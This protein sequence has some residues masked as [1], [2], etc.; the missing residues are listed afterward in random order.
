MSFTNELAVNFVVFIAY[1]DQSI[2]MPDSLQSRTSGWTS[3]SVSMS[4]SQSCLPTICGKTYIYFI[5]QQRVSSFLSISNYLFAVMF[6]HEHFSIVYLVMK[7]KS[8]F[9]GRVSNGNNNTR[10]NTITRCTL[11]V[12]VT[13]AATIIEYSLPPHP[14]SPKQ[15][16]INVLHNSYITLT[17]LIECMLPSS[18][19]TTSKRPTEISSLRDSPAD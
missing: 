19:Q 4:V 10:G 7:M 1:S 13:I 6:I 12:T 5:Y 9:D 3:D 16:S 18:R 8:T 15:P 17:H 2:V 11:H 14:L